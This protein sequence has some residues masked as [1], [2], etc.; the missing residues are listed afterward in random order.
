MLHGAQ[1]GLEGIIGLWQRQEITCNSNVRL[2]L[3]LLVLQQ[4]LKP[5]HML[6]IPDLTAFPNA[7]HPGPICLPNC[8]PY[9]SWYPSQ[10]LPIGGEAP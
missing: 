4:F 3:V 8:F 1:G 7:S 5:S 10:I 6:P 2:V 9:C